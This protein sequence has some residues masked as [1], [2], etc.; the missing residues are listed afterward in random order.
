M[1]LGK[2]AWMYSWVIISFFIILIPII[3]VNWI[4]PLFNEFTKLKEGEL[5]D[6]IDEYALKVQFPLKEIFIVDGSKRSSHSNAYFTGFGK[7]KRIV[8]YDTLLKNH[9]TNEI[10]SIIAHEVGHYKKKHII[11]NTIIS[12]AMT[13]IMLFCLS[14]FIDNLYL[15]QAFQMQNISTYAGIVFFSILYSPINFLLSIFMNYFSRLNE[16]EADKYA[17]ETTGDRSNLILAL[18]NL[19][20]S[21]LSNLTVDSAF[22]DGGNGLY[23]NAPT[24]NDNINT[25]TELLTVD[26]PENP[27][28]NNELIAKY[29]EI[30]SNDQNFRLGRIIESSKVDD[31][32]N[33][34]LKFEL[35]TPMIGNFNIG[36]F[37]IGM[38]S[39]C[40]AMI[41]P[42]YWDEIGL[43]KASDIDLGYETYITNKKLRNTT[44]KSPNT[45]NN[46]WSIRKI[47]GGSENITLPLNIVPNKSIVE[48]T[49]KNIEN[50]MLCEP[51][52]FSL[53]FNDNS[54]KKELGFIN[55]RADDEKII[56]NEIVSNT[57][58]DTEYN[59]KNSILLSTYNNEEENYVMI[60]TYNAADLEIGDTVYIEDHIIEPFYLKEFI[61][62]LN[63]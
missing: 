15:F 21:N 6:E 16:Y 59:I 34:S 24:N 54:F 1:L 62:G 38:E 35:T 12:I 45:Y 37:I 25:E 48:N 51:V 63:R 43:P 19:S 57:V 58:K 61:P 46:N 28:M 53:L 49:G 4:A 32:G 14:F 47:D 20:I 60:E 18:K 23:V 26:G 10:I 8:L 39:N 56:F 7:N 42:Y 11:I 29:D 55:T 36:D 41:V 13:G 9:S 27:F 17:V 3:Y 30:N 31:N 40:L 50:I 33:Y 2:Y 22:K 5:K 52:E 44:L